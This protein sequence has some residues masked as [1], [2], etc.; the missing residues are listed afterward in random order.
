[1]KKMIPFVVL[2]AVAIL[3][4]CV[5]FAGITD[6]AR[7]QAYKTRAV[8][9]DAVIH[10]GYSSTRSGGRY[11]AFVDYEI[12]G[13]HIEDAQLPSHL[14][15]SRNSNDGDIVTIYVDPDKVSRFRVED[16][17]TPVMFKWLGGFFLLAGAI[18][19]AVMTKKRFSAGRLVETGVKVMADICDVVDGYV[20]VN[21]QQSKH[22][23]CEWQE[24]GQTQPRRFKSKALFMDVSATIKKAGLKQL[25]VYLDSVKPNK[26]YVDTSQLSEGE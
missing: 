18:P 26:Y 21:R 22:I 19:L 13:V 10:V 12:G 8:A 25:P 3:G 11:A 1:M 15:D 16:P 14:Y 7:W 23:I 5:L 20:V 2:T 4:A 24:V 9:I 17:V 6:S